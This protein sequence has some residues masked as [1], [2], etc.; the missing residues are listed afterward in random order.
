[1]TRTRAARLFLAATLMAG[2]ACAAAQADAQ[3]RLEISVR[4]DASSD[5][6][7]QRVQVLEGR[8][9]VIYTGRSRPARQ[10]QYVQT[11]GGVVPQQIIVVQE[12]TT[13]FDVVARLAGDKDVLLDFSG[14]S[15]RARLG[16]WIEL[17]RIGSATAY[18]LELQGVSLKVDE[19]RD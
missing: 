18:R 12:E 11:P 3:R 7:D 4:F 8:R 13:G 16:E 19:V 2:C 6:V 1:M 10:R 9:A 17:G 15:V 14:A 5:G